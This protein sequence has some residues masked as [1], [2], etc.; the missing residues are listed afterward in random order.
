LLQK[1][2]TRTIVVNGFNPENIALAVR[3]E[4]IG[5]VIQ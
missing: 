3:G 2:R 5:T 4:N 1:K